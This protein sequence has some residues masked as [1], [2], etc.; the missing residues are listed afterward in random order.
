M[1]LNLIVNVITKPNS[2]FEEITQNFSSQYKMAMT[3]F[4][5][6]GLIIIFPNLVEMNHWQI[7]PSTSEENLLEIQSISMIIEVTT[8]II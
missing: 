8:T 5:V 2:F 7:E 6:A 4:L 1:N 3:I